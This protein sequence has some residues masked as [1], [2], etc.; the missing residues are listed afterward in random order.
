MDDTF[1]VT[2]EIPVPAFNQNPSKSFVKDDQV[3]VFV[4]LDDELGFV[5]L[6]FD[7]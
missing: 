1:S 2:A 3:W 7:L 6:S 5:R 4:N